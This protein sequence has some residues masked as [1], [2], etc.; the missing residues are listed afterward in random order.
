MTKAR[1]MP[2]SRAMMPYCASVEL[3]EKGSPFDGASVKRQLRCFQALGVN[4]S[5]MG[6]GEIFITPLNGIYSAKM[7]KIAAETA[8]AQ[9]INV[10]ITV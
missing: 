7:M 3:E 5:R 1:H 6:E 9:A 8:I 4:A 10:P 2:R